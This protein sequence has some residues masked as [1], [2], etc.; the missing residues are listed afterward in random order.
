MESDK[1]IKIVWIPGHYG[2]EGNELADV[3]AKQA[4]TNR[5]LPLTTVQVPI[6]FEMAQIRESFNELLQNVLRSR[7]K[8]ASLTCQESRQ[9]QQR[10]TAV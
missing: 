9:Y 5:E 7:N 4:S 6:S 10:C 1:E 3:A 8:K 2:I